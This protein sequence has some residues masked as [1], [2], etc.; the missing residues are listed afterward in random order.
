METF[1]RQAIKFT[2]GGNSAICS[3]AKCRNM[4]QIYYIGYKKTIKLSSE[5]NL[6]TL[7][8]TEFQ[9][10]TFLEGVSRFIV[11]T[12]TTNNLSNKGAVIFRYC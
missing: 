3:D 4:D 1:K 7:D 5:L 12:P 11:A 8:V 6:S 10:N 2:K 9:P